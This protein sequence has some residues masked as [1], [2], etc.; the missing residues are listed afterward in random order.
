[1]HNNDTTSVSLTNPD[2]HENFVCDQQCSQNSLHCSPPS[3]PIGIQFFSFRYNSVHSFKYKQYL[4][5]WGTVVIISCLPPTRGHWGFPSKHFSYYWA[6][7]CF[8]KWCKVPFPLLHSLL[9]LISVTVWTICV[10]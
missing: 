7:V 4:L 8:F 5:D 9:E 2:N 3:K 10:C 1:M 6:P